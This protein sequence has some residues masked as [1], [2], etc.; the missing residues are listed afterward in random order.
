MFELYL[1]LY[2]S[3]TPGGRAAVNYFEAM[4]AHSVEDAVRAPRRPPA[5]ARTP[6]GY[7]L[8]VQAPCTVYLYKYRELFVHCTHK[9]TRN[10]PVQVC[11]RN[12]LIGRLNSCS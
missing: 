3:A 7:R 10:R 4:R 8:P 6:K 9:N 12:E 11:I 2:H 5:R 1:E